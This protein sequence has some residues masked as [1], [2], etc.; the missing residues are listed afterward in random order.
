MRI[1]VWQ[2]VQKTPLSSSKYNEDGEQPNDVEKE[3][4]Q[5]R[6][7]RR[8]TMIAQ[9]LLIVY[10]V[11]AAIGGTG[12]KGGF[13]DLTA[14]FLLLAFFYSSVYLVARAGNFRIARISVEDDAQ[15]LGFEYHPW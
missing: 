14:A 13:V 6:R 10:L 12:M 2:A 8:T 4:E 5:M 15:S 11:I 7:E 1:Q 3:F 9:Y